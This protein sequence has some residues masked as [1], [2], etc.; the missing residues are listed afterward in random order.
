M[1]LETVWEPRVRI[2]LS[3]PHGQ[4]LGDQLLQ[5]LRDP[6]WEVFRAA[7]A[8]VKRSGMN[9][10]LNELRAFA[11]RSQVRMAVGVDL[12]GTS[13]EG[14]SALLD[15]LE[16]QGNI[17]V[18]HNENGSTFHPKLYLFK[19]RDRAEIIVGSGN[20]TEGGLF[21]N[22]EASI[23]VSLNLADA[24]DQ[25]FLA[26]VEAV[27]DGYEDETS[28]TSIR[29]TRDTL[30]RLTVEGY[31]P[32]EAYSRRAEEGAPEL[33]PEEDEPDAG[34]FERVPVPAPPRVPARA[35]AATAP[36]PVG[37]GAVVAPAAPAGQASVFYMTLMRTDAGTGQ[38]TAG[39]QRRS[40]EVFIPLAARD[41]AP[42]FWDWPTG[43]A[44]DATEAGKLDRFGVQ[45]LIGTATESVTM[46]YFPHRHE[47]RLRSEPLR[48]AGAI[49]D[50]L[51]IEKTDGS[52]GY[53]YI[54]TV[55][56]QGTAQYAAA[57]AKCVN[58]VKASRKVWGYE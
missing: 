4:R 36:A 52:R 11:A 22:Y 27:L 32:P 29:L 24:E 14:L 9:H 12:G 51:R 50:I 17:W 41:F 34:L 2:L 40:P 28:G 54:A 49:G 15:C 38:T 43:F 45:M 20:L 30:D 3:Q 33:A 18:V 5:R 42:T 31:L 25:A 44:A 23:A 19:S 6:A 55:I 47:F 46:T 57:L 53:Q 39:T 35:A 7:V 8:F 1:L 10:L 13:L 48:S 56:P 21:D 37:G 58:Q 16:G 26:Q